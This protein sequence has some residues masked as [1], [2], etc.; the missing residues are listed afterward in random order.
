MP[1]AAYY[2]AY[3]AAHPDYRK[4]EAARRAAR[5]RAMTPEE[6]RKD[7]GQRKP[8]PRFEPLMP[9]MPAL[10][11]GT[12]ISYWEDELR[13]DLAQE[14]QLAVLEGVDPKVAVAAYRRRENAWRHFICPFLVDGDHL[15]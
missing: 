3:R 7:R 13:L 5:R 6:R 9:L 8:A 12:A 10:Q 4:R 2:R 11:H 1:D 14:A 15:E